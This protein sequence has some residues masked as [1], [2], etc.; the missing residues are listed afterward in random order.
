M[1]TPL[2]VHIT[3][4]SCNTQFAVAAGYVARKMSAGE[5]IRCPIC[6]ATVMEPEDNDVRQ[7]LLEAC[8]GLVSVVESF[9]LRHPEYPD[10][11]DW[12]LLAQ[13]QTAIAKA[14]GEGE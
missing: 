14:E 2:N 4:M 1:T 13:G 9:L 5:P 8:K 10:E 3:C 7:E 11:T 12:T 6:H